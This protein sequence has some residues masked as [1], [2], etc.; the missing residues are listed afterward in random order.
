MSKFLPL[1]QIQIWTSSFFHY[2]V[3][4]DVC[5]YRE[6]SN[7]CRSSGVTRANG[8]VLTDMGIKDY[9]DCVLPLL[10]KRMSSSIFL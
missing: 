8:D 9:A 1:C 3:M 10:Q 2:D 6:R 5:Q 4:L 7:R